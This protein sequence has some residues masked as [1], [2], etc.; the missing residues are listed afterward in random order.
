MGFGDLPNDILRDIF[1]PRK[2]EVHDVRLCKEVDIVKAPPPESLYGELKLR[3]DVNLYASE[4]VTLFLGKLPT[5][6]SRISVTLIDSL[7]AQGG[8]V[9]DHVL[10]FLKR[11]LL[12]KYLFNMDITNITQYSGYD[13]NISEHLLHFCISEQFCRLVYEMHMSSPLLETIF[14]NWT[15]RNLNCNQQSR[16][17]MCFISD[18]EL[19]KLQKSLQLQKGPLELPLWTRVPNETSTELSAF[20]FVLRKGRCFAKDR[21]QALLMFLSKDHPVGWYKN[22]RWLLYKIEKEPLEAEDVEKFTEAD[23]DIVDY[24]D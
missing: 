24:S 16:R 7:D 8:I 19:G 3:Y 10:D 15:T 1:R 11:Q 5:R 12:S 22:E 20:L 17:L 21:E 18:G 4:E 2:D 14:K 6:F 13:P 23:M 9:P